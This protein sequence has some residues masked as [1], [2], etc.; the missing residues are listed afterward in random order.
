MNYFSPWKNDVVRS[1]YFCIS[2][3][4]VP[5]SSALTCLGF[6]AASQ[7]REISFNRQT[8]LLISPPV[9]CA[10][11]ELERGAR[12]QR[13]LESLFTQGES[14]FYPLANRSWSL[15]SWAL[16]VGQALLF[17]VAAHLHSTPTQPGFRGPDPQVPSLL[18][19]VMVTCPTKESRRLPYAS[20]MSPPRGG[21]RFALVIEGLGCSLLTF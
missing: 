19:Q 17:T 1:K 16:G 6:H 5:L 14:P 12:S 9:Q 21:V 11:G 13:P 2:N 3:T 20:Q 7:C 15:G 18:L 4:R 8:A 10:F